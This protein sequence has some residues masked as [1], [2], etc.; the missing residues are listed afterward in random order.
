[1]LSKKEG[2]GTRATTQQLDGEGFSGSGQS[3]GPI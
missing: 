2:G 3:P 1:M